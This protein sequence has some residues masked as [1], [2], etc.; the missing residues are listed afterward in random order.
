[1]RVC[2]CA[3]VSVCVW[4]RNVYLRGSLAFFSAEQ[5]RRE[6]LPRPTALG[7][8]RAHHLSS[9]LSFCPH[10]NWIHD[11]RCLGGSSFSKRRQK[12]ANHES[13]NPFLRPK[14][15][16]TYSHNQVFLHSQG[17]KSWTATQRS[18]I[19]SPDTPLVE[20]HCMLLWSHTHMKGTFRN[21]SW[22]ILGMSIVWKIKKKV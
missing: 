17:Q 2:I 15:T 13:L 11:I 5:A 12:K 19:W 8:E 10:F 20:K 16:S 6:G 21:A 3:C 22:L 14:L 4:E 7:G 9:R 1:M 18:D